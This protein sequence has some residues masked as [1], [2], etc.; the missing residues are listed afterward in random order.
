VLRHNNRRLR[1][2]KT[3]KN[4]RRRATVRRKKFR[5]CHCPFTS[6]WEGRAANIRR[7][8]RPTESATA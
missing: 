7:A 1:A 2:G 6:G 5:A 3:V 4:R 8:R